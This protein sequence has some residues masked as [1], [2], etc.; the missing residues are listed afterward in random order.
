MASKNSSLNG[1]DRAS[2]CT[3]NTPS[4]NPASRILWLFSTALNHRSVAQTCT[5][6][7]RQRKIEDVARP[8]PRSSTRIP[9]CRSRADVSHSAI[10]SGLAA[11]LMLARSHSRLYCEERGNR[12]EMSGLFEIVFSLRLELYP[13]QRQMRNRLPGS[14]VYRRRMRYAW[15]ETIQ[16]LGFTMMANRLHSSRLDTE[17]RKDGD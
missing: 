14:Q 16:C 8:Q 6:N 2:A 10:Q 1:S 3:G 17:H 12:S 13:V 4:S 11:P 5:P 15:P 9:G 7:S